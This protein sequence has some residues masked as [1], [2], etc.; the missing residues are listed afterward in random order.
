MRTDRRDVRTCTLALIAAALTALVTGVRAQTPVKV[1]VPQAV[2]IWVALPMGSAWN[3]RWQ[4]V[5]G[6]V[7]AGAA[8]VP[9]D[10]VLE[11][12]AAA[13]TDTGHSSNALSGAFGMLKPGEPNVELQKD[14]ATR[15]LHL[16]AVVG[17]G[18]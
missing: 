8:S 5:G 6:G 7:Y 10:A 13:T 11:G 14:F 15:S 17:K 16:M 4:S 12:Y 1:L 3:G 9:A 18:T 2:N